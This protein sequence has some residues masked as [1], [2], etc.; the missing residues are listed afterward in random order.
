VFDRIRKVKC[1]EAKPFCEK[2]VRTGRTCDGYESPFRVLTRETINGGH[3]AEIKLVSSLQPIRSTSSRITPG[4]ID[5]LNRY[6]SIKTMFNIELG[7]DQ[8]ARRILQASLAEPSLRHA[9]S[10][11]RALREDLEMTGDWP[12]SF[13]QQTPCHTDG[14]RQYNM[15]LV[16]LASKLSSLGPESLDSALLCCQ[17]FIS[18]EQVRKNY[19]AMAQHIIQGL[20]IMHEYRARPYLDADNNL[21]SAHH[22]EVP[23]LDVFVVKIFAAPCK[24]ADPPPE[25]DKTKP[26]L[27][28][29]RNLPQLPR[30]EAPDLRTIAPNMRS[31][32][33]RIATLTLKFLDEVSRVESTGNA[34][35]LLSEKEVILN[36]LKSWL[37]NLEISQTHMT[38]G[39]EPISVSFSRLF[40]MI[41]KIVLLGALNSSSEIKVELSTEYKQLQTLANKLNERLRTYTT[42]YWNSARRRERSMIL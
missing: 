34:L 37:F 2:C 41:L 26:T 12:T 21:T 5:L 3:A 6:F 33:T 27:S 25:V 8:E 14:L 28:L 39:I 17:V 36:S 13:A 42:S 38:F 16:G 31:E 7:C 40:H 1:D 9:V 19:A 32:L 22:K 4:E 29:D 24:F 18:I 20:R 23:L 30:Y 35:R 10:S 15:A 11:L